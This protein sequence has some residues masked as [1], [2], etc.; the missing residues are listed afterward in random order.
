MNTAGEAELLAEV[1][2]DVERLC[3]VFLGIST[4]AEHAACAL[5]AET[6]DVLTYQGQPYLSVM[7]VGETEI[8]QL[9]AHVKATIQ[10]ARATGSLA[11][12]GAEPDGPAG[13]SDTGGGGGDSPQ[14]S[15]ATL[16]ASPSARSAP[17]SGSPLAPQP[18]VTLMPRHQ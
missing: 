15:S 5:R 11:M 12:S 16:G 6:G 9:I 18:S 4:V 2:P 14:A 7:H 1:E 8:L 13:G 17:T 10:L 3:A